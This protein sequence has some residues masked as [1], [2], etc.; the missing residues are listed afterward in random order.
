[1]AMAMYERT[2]GYRPE[3]QLEPAGRRLAHQEFFEHQRMQR[4]LRCAVGLEHGRH[5]IAESQDAA[6]LEPD[7][8]H[9]ARQV[10]RKRRDHALSF[11]LGLIDAT[12]REEGAPAA[13]R[14]GG[15]ICG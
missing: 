8:R 10:W 9:A 7:H 1:M 14:T 13:E 3:R 12:N 2:F 6:R 5:F 4:K 15:A 11:T